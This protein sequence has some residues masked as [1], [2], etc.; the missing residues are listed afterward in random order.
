MFKLPWPVLHPIC[1]PRSKDAYEGVVTK[2]WLEGELPVHL[3]TV[4]AVILEY[5]NRIFF[6]LWNCCT[7][8]Y[9][10]NQP[11]RITEMAS[12]LCSLLFFQQ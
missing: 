5:R 12:L 6:L 2:S 9:K 1:C 10:D 8:K 4:I 7:A 11:V 3:V